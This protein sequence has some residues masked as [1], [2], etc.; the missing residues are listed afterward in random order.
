MQKCLLEERHA[1]VLLMLCHALELGDDHEVWDGLP[2][3]LSARLTG[4]ELVRLLEA[5]LRAVDADQAA[6][7]LQDHMVRVGSPLPVLTDID[8]DARWWADLASPGEIKAWLS[9]CY[10]RLSPRDRA[11]F[12]DAATGRAAA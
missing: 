7:V 8:H 4:D 6:A 2:V 5:L 10:V 11:E 1:R 3:V 9:A 12:L